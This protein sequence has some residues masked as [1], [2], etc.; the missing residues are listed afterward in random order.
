[1]LSSL[2]I[3]DCVWMVCKFSDPVKTGRPVNTVHCNLIEGVK[4]VGFYSGAVSG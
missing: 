4:N 1:M 3:F 2:T